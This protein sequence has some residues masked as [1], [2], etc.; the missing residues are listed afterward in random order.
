[1]VMK[2]Q[3]LSLHIN[4]SRIVVEHNN[5]LFGDILCTALEGGSNYWIETIKFLPPYNKPK[6]CSV[7]EY[8]T[9]ELNAGK[10]IQI[11]D[12]DNEHHDLTMGDLIFGIKRWA[13]CHPNRVSIITENG[14]S[15][16]DAGNIDANEADTILQ[17]ALFGKWVFG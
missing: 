14:R 15:E 3:H 13:H 17:Y 1:M 4:N 16:I 10:T 2:K 12:V 5:E 11:V 8:A 9:S 7:S 6:G